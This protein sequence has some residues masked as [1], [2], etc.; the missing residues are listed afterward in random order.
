MSAPARARLR[1]RVARRRTRS[2]VRPR[3]R[4]TERS[5]RPAPGSRIVRAAMAAALAA[6]ALFWFSLPSVEPLRHAHP[7]VTV[8]ME[9][10]AEEAREKGRAARRNQHWVPLSSISPWL[11]KAVV[12][13]ED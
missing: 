4:P 1:L 5:R 6:A 11:Q 3:P 12:N 8:L 13:S 9:A 2:G 10:R 7:S